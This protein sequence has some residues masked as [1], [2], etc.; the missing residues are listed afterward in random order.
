MSQRKEWDALVEGAGAYNIE[1][2]ITLSKGRMFDIDEALDITVEASSNPDSY[3]E[4]G[5]IVS[6]PVQAP[7]VRRLLDGLEEQGRA[8]TKRAVFGRK[9][10]YFILPDAELK[11]KGI[12]EDNEALRKIM[13]VRSA[14]DEYT[15]LD[16]E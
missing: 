1:R 13:N 14:G 15:P 6:H 2:F 4:G 16:D 11:A 8:E 7:S 9:K 10:G 12:V 3:K 5:E